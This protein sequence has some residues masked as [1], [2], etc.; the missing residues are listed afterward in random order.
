MTATSP[1]S[2]LEELDRCGIG[3]RASMLLRGQLDTLP[4]ASLVGSTL[5]LLETLGPTVEIGARI[6]A[7]MPARLPASAPE[8]VFI[9]IRNLRVTYA[10]FSHRHSELKARVDAKGPAD[11]DMVLSVARSAQEWALMA[12]LLRR[13]LQE[14]EQVLLSAVA[15]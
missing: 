11:R 3:M 12:L 1:L 15:A 5:D 14:T 8:E 7:S 6:V 2:I 13:L 4:T 9:S 10:A